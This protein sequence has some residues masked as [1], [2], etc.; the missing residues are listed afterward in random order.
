[1]SNKN[2]IFLPDDDLVGKNQ[3]S[4]PVFDTIASNESFFRSE[5]ARSIYAIDLI[6]VKIQSNE[7]KRERKAFVRGWRRER[8]NTCPRCNNNEEVWLGSNKKVCFNCFLR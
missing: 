6:N 1:M 2:S 5:N 7:C 4:L 3:S 8:I